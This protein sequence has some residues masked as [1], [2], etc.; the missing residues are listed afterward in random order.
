MAVA[1]LNLFRCPSGRSHHSILRETEDDSPTPAGPGEGER[2]AARPSPDCTH[3]QIRR[4]VKSAYG[5]ERPINSRFRIRLTGVQVNQDV[6]RL[7]ALARANDAAILQLV[8]DPGRASV[9]EP[10]PPL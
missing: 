6:P 4:L 10:Q 9:A 8:H 5:L 3:R 1:C 7:G 2:L